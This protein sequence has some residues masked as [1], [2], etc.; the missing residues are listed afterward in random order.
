MVEPF[1]SHVHTEETICYLDSKISEQVFQE[2]ELISKHHYLEHYPQLIRAC[3]PLV[4]LWTMRFK[5]KHI[6]F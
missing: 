5:T 6:F 3:G 1:V 2:E 4:L